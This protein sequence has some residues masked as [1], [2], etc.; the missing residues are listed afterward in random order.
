MAGL[1]AKNSLTIRNLN[2]FPPVA[3]A[4]MVGL[5]HSALRS[6]IQEQGGVGLLFS[7]MLAARGLADE[8]EKHSPM[9]VRSADEK[10]LFYQ[11]FLSDIS[12]IEPAVERLQQ[13]NAQGIDLN[14]GCPAPKLRRQ[15]AGCFLL[16]DSNRLRLVVRKLRKATSLPLS[17]K[18]RLGDRLD[19]GALVEFCTMLCTEGIDLLT[20]H[21]RLHGEKFCRK[22]RWEWIGKIKERIPIPV[23]ANGGIFSV[24]DARQCLKISN[25]DG[26]MIGR[27]AALRPWLF[28]DIGHE[29]YG[30]ATP[31]ERPSRERVYFRFIELL[32][33]RF[34]VERRLGRLKQFTHY[35]AENYMFGHQLAT[36][37]QT[38][39][40]MDQAAERAS[41]FFEQ[42]AY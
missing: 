33:E 19:Q 2:I 24:G 14:L 40:S 6:L 36:A 34:V 31:G 42:S 7:E 28:A 23:L 4:P 8:N 13:L 26:L 39:I 3:L 41:A 15:G 17:A 29:I 20:V 5:S 10:P 11:I 9:L 1:P 16:K 12:D 38:S 18:I 21:G 32:K 35:F 27:G 25:A 22:P 37:I 30:M